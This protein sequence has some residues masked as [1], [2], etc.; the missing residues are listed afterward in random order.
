MIHQTYLKNKKY[1]I[2]TPSNEWE[3]FDGVFKNT[4]EQ[5]IR[6][7]KTKNKSISATPDHRLYMNGSEVFVR[8]LKKGMFIDSKDG[9]EEIISIR[10]K[11]I[12]STYDIF[13]CKNH[14]IMANYIASHQCDEFAA[15]KSV[16][17]QREFW[18]SIQ[19]V[20]STGGDCILTTTPKNDED[21]FSQIWKG[22]ID[23]TDEYGNL[24]NED[25][26]G[27]N[28]FYGILIPW[29][30]HPERDE[31]WAKPF[32]ESL[33]EARFAQEFNCCVFDT[34]IEILLQNNEKKI[35]SIGELFNQLKLKD[36]KEYVENKSN[37]KVLTENG[38]KSFSGIAYMGDEE[39][40]KVIFC[41]NTFLECTG[42]HR[43]SNIKNIMVEVKN[44]KIGDWIK[45]K[46]GK[47]TKVKDIIRTNKIQAVYDLVD[48]DGHHYYTNSVLSHNCQFITDDET[49]INPLTLTRLTGRQPVYFTGTVRWYFEPEPNKT[50]LVALDPSLGTGGDYGAIQVFQLPEM[51]QIAEWQHN[52]TVPRGQVRVLMQVLLYLNETLKC[53][54]DQKGDPDIYWTVENN[55][56][57]EAILQIIEDTGEERF[58]GIFISER[59]RK[60]VARGRFRK[61]MT[62]NKRNKLSACARLKSLIESGRATVSSATLIRQFKNFVASDASFAAK[63]GEHDD[64]ISAL[65]LI[66]RM[67]DVV[68]HFGATVGDLREYIDDDELMDDGDAMPIVL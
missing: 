40:Y 10:N 26:S 51:K 19:P 61:G 15:I 48:V 33:G 18:T 52:N 60:G 45:C 5:S 67:I 17:L 39:I 41:N 65:L 1:E 35:V 47:R 21:M 16:D 38:F 44:L 62:T 14:K 36:M 63:P 13:N 46:N 7:I 59:K 43:I 2:L 50:F 25:G 27:K 30:E 56:I 42:N 22:A 32:R 37:I 34:N 64:L 55:T 58:P 9:Q 24:L 28:G 11:K 68:N 54:P 49:L 20:L 31:E 12:S 53:D 3:S 23:N 57:G 6:V 8:E 4:G 29:H 66:T